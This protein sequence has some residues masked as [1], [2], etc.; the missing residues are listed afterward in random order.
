MPGH[1]SLARGFLCDKHGYARRIK[2]DAASPGPNR[3]INPGTLTD[4]EWDIECF[5]GE[6]CRDERSRGTIGEGESERWDDQ[7]DRE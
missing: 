5:R 1:V 7:R 4:I 2:I 3:K 6:F